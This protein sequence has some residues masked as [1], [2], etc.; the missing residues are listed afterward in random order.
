MT[1]M[2]R[3]AGGVQTVDVKISIPEEPRIG[4][5]WIRNHGT[6][7]TFEELYQ[8][9]VN[10]PAVVQAGS[11]LANLPASRHFW[12]EERM[13]RRTQPIAD[14][15]SRASS[16]ATGNPEISLVLRRDW[17]RIGPAAL[18]QG[19]I[20]YTYLNAEAKI[21]LVI[22]KIASREE[23]PCCLD[24]CDNGGRRLQRTRSLA[25]Y[26]LWPAWEDRPD[27][28]PPHANL[29]LRPRTS[30]LPRILY[31]VGAVAGLLIGF[32]LL[33]FILGLR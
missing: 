13:M 9:C 11:I 15:L 31:V 16:G 12:C 25:D 28:F 3:Q 33:R 21:D 4:S 10:H 27:Q 14:A 29:S 32:I 30:W 23:R 19:G 6:H 1:S 7:H 26:G 17:Y 18:V 2:D 8:E 22:Q 20:E 24:M 5:F